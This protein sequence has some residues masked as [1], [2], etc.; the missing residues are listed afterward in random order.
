MPNGYKT[1]VSSSGLHKNPAN[2]KTRTELMLSGLEQQR[3]SIYDNQIER[4][5]M[6]I[7]FDIYDRIKTEKSLKYVCG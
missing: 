6:E 7:E 4:E 2:D 3:L 5:Y 1:G